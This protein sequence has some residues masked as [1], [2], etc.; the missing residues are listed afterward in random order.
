MQIGK[1]PESVLKRSIL[2]KINTRRDEVLVH[3]GVGEDC[4]VVSVGADEVVVLSTDPITGTVHDIG[5]LA[6]L[7]T[8]NDIASA[9]AETI[10]ILAT[11]LLP[12]GTSEEELR[13]MMIQMEEICATY[14]MEILGG[15][16]EI[17]KAVNQ[18]V[19]TVTGIGKMKRE[20]LITTGGMKPGNELVMTKWAGTEGTAILACD[21]EDLLK[22]R[23]SQEFID[24]AKSFS[25]FLSVI[26]DAKIAMEVGVSAMHDVTEG[27]IFGALWEM[28]SAS[29]CGVQ[30]ELADIPIRQ[31]T[32]E[33]SNFFDINPYM[34][35]SSGSMLIAT[36]YANALVAKLTCAGIP[37]AVIGRAIEGKDKVILSGGERRF[38]EPPKSDELYTAL[39]KKFDDKID[40]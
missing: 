36:S 29:G 1:V 34:L 27:G 40:G 18:P 14:D 28:A 7:I 8:S 4:S 25:Q 38:L 16:T 37:A 15:H 19:I 3:P 13:T 32:V 9:G 20:H 24:D 22:T 12:D 21:R 2:N 30:V 23:F 39:E 17:S 31:E 35:I 6:A 33:I 5:R 10:G 26:E 11:I